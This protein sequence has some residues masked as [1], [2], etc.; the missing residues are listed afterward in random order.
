MFPMGPRFAVAG[1]R[2]LHLAALFGQTNVIAVLL[3]SGA[4]VNATNSTG[5]TA[6]D[7]ASSRGFPRGMPSLLRALSTRL[8]PQGTDES[9]GPM[10]FGSLFERQKAAASQLKNAGGK[11]SPTAQPGSGPFW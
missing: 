2:P 6:L 8:E 9:A 5:R 11:S 1:N 3:K 10:P 4:L 7:L